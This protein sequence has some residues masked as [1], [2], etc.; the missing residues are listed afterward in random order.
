MT[1]QGKAA[2]VDDAFLD[3]KSP[4]GSGNN[5]PASIMSR[6][7]TPNTSTNPTPAG[8]DAEESPSGP[9]VRKKKKPT[10]CVR[11][12]GSAKSVLIRDHV[13]QEP[14]ESYRGAPASKVKSPSNLVQAPY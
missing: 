11:I 3:A 5:T 13:I 9:I 6:R 14:T 10:R 7:Q 2:I 12:S 8:S 4:R 1:H